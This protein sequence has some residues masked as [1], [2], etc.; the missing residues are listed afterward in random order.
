MD[1]SL[2]TAQCVA[3]GLFPPSEKEIWNKSLKLWQPIPIHTVPTEQD[4]PLL[5]F[6][7]NISDPSCPRYSHLIQKYLNSPEMAALLKNHSDFIGFLEKK[8]GQK[9]LSLIDIYNIYDA[10]LIQKLKGFK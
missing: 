9:N 5:R 10:L 1:R 6:F 8:S 2:M 3:T 4:F 7:V